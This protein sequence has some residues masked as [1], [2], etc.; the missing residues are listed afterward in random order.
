MRFSLKARAAA[1]ATVCV[2]VC[3]AGAAIAASAGAASSDDA[4]FVAAEA[5]V[6]SKARSPDPSAPHTASTQS[7][8]DKILRVPGSTR[9]YTSGELSTNFNAPDW[10]PQDHPRPPRIVLHGTKPVWACGACHY[11]NG[12]G[13]TTSAMLAGL[14]KAYILEQVAAF[15]EGERRPPDPEMPEEARNLDKADLQ[16]AADYFS[17][18][19][20]HPIRR[21]VET[22]SVPKTHW[23]GFV[24]AP[25][26]DGAREPIG[27]RIIEVSDDQKLYDLGDERVG[28]VA[29]VPPG[30][31]EAGAKIA[32]QGRGSASACESCH[33]A[34]LQGAD[35]PGIGIAPPLAGRSPT[36]LARELILFRLGR[37]TNPGAAPMRTEVSHLTLQDMI[38]VAAYAGSRKP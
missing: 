17:N 6:F 21:I 10:F 30:S 25:D 22:T 4:A 36:Y 23:D 7:N 13:D 9:R 11:P 29:Y 28:F 26:R 19:K 33:A 20:L 15:R 35:L 34:N 5:W 24:L 14:P 27:E 38:D 16:Q 31:I 37:R 2:F 8:P 18:L 1:C 3:V 12:E 32:A